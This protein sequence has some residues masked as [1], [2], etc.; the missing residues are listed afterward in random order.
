VVVIAPSNPFLS[1]GPMLAV[2]GIRRALAR[3]HGPVVAVSPLVGGRAVSGPLA[4]LLRRFGLPRSS[5]GIAA[6]Y[7]PFVDALVIDGRDRRD[8]PALRALGCNPIVTGTIF[9]T[10]ARAARAARRMLAALEAS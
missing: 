10:P 5:A 9:D 2:P 4:R 3:R 7:R 6:C 8:V 1:I